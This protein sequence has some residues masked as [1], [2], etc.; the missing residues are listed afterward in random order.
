L[1]SVPVGYQALELWD[2]VRSHLFE[3]AFACVSGATELG[4]KLEAENWKAFPEVT[5]TVELAGC[6]GGLEGMD[7]GG[8]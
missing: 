6:K 5:V 8:G 4:S 2:A 1:G 3:E 7:F